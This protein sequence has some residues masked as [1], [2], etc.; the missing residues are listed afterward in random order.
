MS[1]SIIIGRDA[2]RAHVQVPPT[3]TAVSRA[4]ARLTSQPDGRYLLE[5]LESAHGTFVF[6]KGEW[7]RIGQALVG[8]TTPLLLADYRT[9]VGELLSR[10][11]TTA[12]MVPGAAPVILPP[13]GA[14]DQGYGRPP[15]APRNA[16]P[17]DPVEA[18]QP[19]PERMAMF[20]AAEAGRPGAQAVEARAGEVQPH[21][22][23]LAMIGIKDLSRVL[24]TVH[25]PLDGIRG[26]L[27]DPDKALWQ[28]MIAFAAFIGITPF[29]HKEIMLRVGEWVRYP[30]LARGEALENAI[31]VNISAVVSG[32]LA[33]G[34]LSLLPRRLFEPST[35]NLVVAANIYTSMYVAFYTYLADIVK[36]LLFGLMRDMTLPMI[37][38][39][40][41]IGLTLG[42]QLYVWRTVLHL[43][44]GPMLLFLA[45][46]LV[47][48]FL[49]GLFL[50]FTGLVKFG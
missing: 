14:S 49:H 26:L 43:R 22:Q 37:L 19:E 44:W 45:I 29:L 1:M 15:A 17:T 28:A 32:L 35:R 24:M 18:A 5:D 25:R 50:G 13:L 4:H 2:T 10:M 39:L 6:S 38:G 21:E 12:E 3:F 41:V 34:L 47:F 20:A 23:L 42:F 48:G 27:A 36:I 9:T 31:V 8:G 7:H 11:E 30:M 46:G 40:I 16:G 33:F